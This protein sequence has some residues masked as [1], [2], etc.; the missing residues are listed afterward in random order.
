[1]FRK[2]MTLTALVSLMA[3]AACNSITGPATK[4][5]NGS[6]APGRG[7]KPPQQYEK[8]CLSDLRAVEITSPSEGSIVYG[9]DQEL[10]TWV[11][12][13]ICGHFTAELQVSLDNGRTFQSQGVYQDA[14]SASWR[15]P[16]VDGAQT[17]IRVILTDQ[18]GAVSDDMPFT[19][20]L[21]GRHD[22]RSRGRQDQT[23]E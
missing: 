22:G 7:P 23:P 21:V 18:E 2:L 17:V 8:V 19:N 20:R 10:V 13:E 9:G 14:L 6:S 15:V 5:S 4:S 1:M 11:G 12:R 3:L 16:N